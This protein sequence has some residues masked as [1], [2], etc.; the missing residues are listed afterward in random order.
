LRQLHEGVAD[1]AT[2]DA[3][4]R[5]AGCFRMG[6]FELIDLV[7]L[8][9]NFAVTQSVWQAYFNDP[10]FTPS[11]VLREYVAAGWLGRKRGR[12]FFDYA[13]GAAKPAPAT[14][15]A[16]PAPAD[17]V[18]VGDSA[19]TLA[20]KERLAARGIAFRQSAQEAAGVVARA[21]D[22]RLVLTDG[23][24][25]TRRARRDNQPNTLAVDLAL[26]YA[27]ASRLAIAAADSCSIPFGF[28]CYCTAFYNHSTLA[29]LAAAD[30]ST[31]ANTS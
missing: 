17:I 5:E 9:I 6:P 1:C 25:A 28:S 27:Q 14:E 7:G 15:A 22:A 3:V 16:C 31:I 18:L 13:E 12:G 21:G 30:N 20:L 11:P 8:D 26:D 10:R 24:S 2:L 4:M 29:I 23:C 19:L